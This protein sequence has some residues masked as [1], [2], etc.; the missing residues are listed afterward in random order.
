MIT[1]NKY[2][3]QDFERTNSYYGKSTDAK[4]TGDIPNGSSLY[5]MD[6]K[7]VYMYDEE[8]QSWLVQ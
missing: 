6:T 1:V 8:T 4:P 3:G 5:L 7:Q 2:D